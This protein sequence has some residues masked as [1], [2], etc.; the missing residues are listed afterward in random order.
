VK[1]LLRVLTAAA[2]VVDA[3]V[4]LRLASAYDP[5]RAA[6]SQ[7]TLFRL[8][9]A[10]ALLAALIVLATGAR[11]A[12]LFAFL[13]AVS[14][15]GAVLLYRYVDIGQLGPLPNMYEPAWYGQKV[16]TTIAEAA[17]TLTAAVGALLPRRNRVSA[18]TAPVRAGVPHA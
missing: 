7:G 16:L 8:E 5:V 3:Y 14:A 10:A 12:Y 9:S 2:L 1:L 4:H 6:I 13:V 18:A 17:G 11:L 15:L